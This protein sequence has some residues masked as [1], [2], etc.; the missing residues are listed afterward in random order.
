MN[1]F[2]TYSGVTLDGWNHSDFARC[3]HLGIFLFVFGTYAATAQ[4]LMGAWDI[5]KLVCSGFLE[6]SVF[7]S[8]T[9][10]KTHAYQFFKIVWIVYRHVLAAWGAPCWIGRLLKRAKCVLRR[11]ISLLWKPEVQ[12]T[13]FLKNVGFWFSELYKSGWLVGFVLLASPLAGD[14]ACFN[15]QYSAERTSSQRRMRLL[16]EQLDYSWLVVSNG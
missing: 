3:S 9:C 14:D 16:P 7:Q 11:F 2:S 4:L 15:L 13:A 5:L 12:T 10:V 1:C 8:W 6:V